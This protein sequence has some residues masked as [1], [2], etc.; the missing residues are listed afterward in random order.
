[1]SKAEQLRFMQNKINMLTAELTR[2]DRLLAE[3]KKRDKPIVQDFF[4]KEAEK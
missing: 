1:M 4:K 3:Y 2:K